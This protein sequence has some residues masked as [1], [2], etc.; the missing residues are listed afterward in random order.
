MTSEWTA[1][2]PRR[3]RAGIAL[4]A[5]TTVVLLAGGGSTALAARADKLKKANN[6]AEKES[7]YPNRERLSTNSAICFECFR[8]MAIR[9][10]VNSELTVRTSM[11]DPIVASL[12]AYSN[13]IC[14]LAL[15]ISSSFA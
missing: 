5:G 3:R 13:E 12:W 2:K 7:D 11:G 10:L 4:A 1:L 6:K 14:M 15:K 8:N 9:L